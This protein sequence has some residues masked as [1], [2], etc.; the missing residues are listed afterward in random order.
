MKKL[1]EATGGGE[2]RLYLGRRTRGTISR[3][4]AAL[5]IRDLESAIEQAAINE[6]EMLKR[7]PLPQKPVFA[8]KLRFDLKDSYGETYFSEGQNVRVRR[9]TV[10]EDN[11]VSCV[12][13][14]YDVHGFYVDGAAFDPL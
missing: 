12:K 7:R 4:S 8:A 10:T 6:T 3:E 5:I 14:P 13:Y 1:A 9:R 11:A 2:I